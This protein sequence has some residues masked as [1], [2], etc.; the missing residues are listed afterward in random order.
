MNQDQ[1]LQSVTVE[2]EVVPWK[3]TQCYFIQVGKNGL[4]RLL[5]NDVMHPARLTGGA[6]A[7]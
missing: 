4:A 7:S 5:V 6:E 2:Y 3:L 1:N